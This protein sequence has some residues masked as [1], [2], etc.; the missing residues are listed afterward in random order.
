MHGIYIALLCLWRF[1]EV[2]ASPFRLTQE[3]LANN[4]QASQRPHIKIEDYDCVDGYANITYANGD[5]YEGGC[6]DGFR[7]G[8]GKLTTGN[9][10]EDTTGGT[11]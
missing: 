5:H 6:K 4:N 2:G 8:H 10:T 3:Q 7:S 9:S 1:L 11:D